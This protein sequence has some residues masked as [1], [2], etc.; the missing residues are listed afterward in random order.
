MKPIRIGMLGTW[1]LAG[2]IGTALGDGAAAPLPRL[3]P[4]PVAVAGCR[5]LTVD[6][7]G[8]WKFNP[9][10][11]ASFAGLTAKDAAEWKPIQVP[12]DWAMQG[13]TEAR[14]RG[15]AYL[16]TFT[17]PAEWAGCRI[18]LRCDAVY[19][20]A[21]VYINGKEAGRHEG[22][23]TP[24]ELD[25]TAL[26]QPK[27]ENVIALA[28]K[29]DSLAD[30]LACGTK[31]AYHPIGGISRRI[32]LFALPETNI[33]SL[34]VTTAFDAQYRNATL[35]A[36]LE[37]AQDGGGSFSPLEARLTLT[38]P[39]GK[40]VDLAPAKV[41]ISSPTARIELPVQAPAQWNPEHPNLYTLTIGLYSNGQLLESL[42]QKVGFRQ[43]EVRG[44]QLFVNGQPIKVR[45]INHHE[46]HPLTGRSVADSIDRGDVELFRN[47]NVNLLRTC[48][49]PPNEALL[50]AADE[51][52]MF[53][54]CE[55]PFCW[56]NP[57]KISN[58]VE[59]ATALISQQTAEMAVAYR[60]HPSIVFWS[61][62][63]ESEW[64]PAF[65]ASS[66]LLRSIDP[67]RPQTFNWIKPKKGD[68]G[69]ADILAYH[70]PAYTVKEKAASYTNRPIYIG[71]DAHLNAYNRLELATDQGLRDV[72]GRYLRKLWDLQYSLPG[73]IGQSIWAGIDDVFY[74]PNGDIAGY[75]S[76][77]PLDGW[78]R[79]KPEYWNMKKAYSPV[80]IT[81]VV[82]NG[83]SVE[84]AVENRNVFMN[85]SEMKINWTLGKAS[86]QVSANV[87]ARTNGLL[88]ITLP[89]VPQ[90][91][92]ALN[93]TFT[94]PRGFVADE[95]CLMM[96]PA[97]PAPFG[98]ANGAVA[99]YK[100]DAATGLLSELNGLKL[101][102][103]ELMILAL[104][105]EGTKE[106]NG[107][108]KIW[109]PF[110][111]PCSGWSVTGA[112]SPQAVS[113]SYEQAAGSYRYTAKP[114]GVL[115]IA[116]DFTVKKAINP[117]QVGLV[118]TLPLSC[119]VLS[120]ER[121]GYWDVYPEDHIARL[122]GSV[123]ASE[124]FE[125]TAFG[126]RTQPSHPWRLDKM[127]YGNNDFCSTKHNVLR[128][129]VLDADGHGLVIDGGGQQHIR[130]WRTADAVYVLVADYSNAGAEGF[131]QKLS[132]DDQRNL[133]AGSSVKGVV[134]IKVQ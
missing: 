22:G 111:S 122:K 16:R 72:W 69:F 102:G 88:A 41:A 82:W 65:E 5:E 106:R 128:A 89:A 68:E 27:T 99:N 84:L 1:L 30:T 34:Q 33:S 125:A 26:V 74:L 108:E 79:Q 63:N 91:G 61:L 116:Y 43:I 11:P 121:T 8:T 123:K 117:R 112:V 85:L 37:I 118:F 81:N 32:S 55:A 66:R 13:F 56:A 54:E 38:A 19:S 60:N 14:G 104:N 78:R 86:G 18:K 93:L 36:A 126:P 28:V 96:K 20:D 113:G 131:I 15:V 105:K 97:E 23:F 47:G 57:D 53:I 12:C 134:R 83:R 124:G 25:V 109:T 94:D 133:P 132:Q 62:A 114:G 59:V 75:G 95:F 70:Y 29:N 119:E 103:P 92:Q 4:R 45:G 24:F 71:E 50:A 58:R 110:T 49:Y 80:R 98:D 7:G 101:A 3:S 127:M 76:W 10:A 67:T 73:V 46:I 51:L 9:A 48:H 2:L 35:T 87:P 115:E 52:G 107:P 44:T 100:T 40:N 17:V 130:C 39:D 64:M 120:W 90:P 129:S 31:Y 42:V 77:G 21:V 6:L